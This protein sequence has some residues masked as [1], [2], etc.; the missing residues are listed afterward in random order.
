MQAALLNDFKNFLSNQT[1]GNCPHCS[2]KLIFGAAATAVHGGGFEFF[3]QCL[4][5]LQ[6]EKNF[7]FNKILVI[8]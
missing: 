2:C 3:C 5:V 6:I 1:L 4:E 8:E 7:L